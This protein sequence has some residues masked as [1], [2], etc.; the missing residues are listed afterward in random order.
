M[1]LSLKARFIGMVL[2]LSGCTSPQLAPTFPRV[3]IADWKEA[4]PMNIARNGFAS[5]IVKDKIYIIGGR[6]DDDSLDLTEYTTIQE[7]GSLD[8]WQ[9]GPRLNVKRA[10]MEAVVHGDYIYVAGGGNG[11]GSAKATCCA[12]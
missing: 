4:F 9:L 5:V 1:A 2:L 11:P 3:W 7:S 8:P 12:N 10:F 6:N